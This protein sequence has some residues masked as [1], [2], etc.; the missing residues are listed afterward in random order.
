VEVRA[1]A[2]VHWSRDG[3]KTAADAPTRD[4][5]LGVHVADLATDTLKAGDTVG[6]TFYWPESGHWEG[7]NF[8][9]TVF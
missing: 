9:V 5:G 2:L 1:P 8:T 7:K 3:W 6:L 4:T